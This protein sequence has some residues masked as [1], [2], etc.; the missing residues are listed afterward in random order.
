MQQNVLCTTSSTSYY[1]YYRAWVV[2]EELSSL[3]DPSL[4]GTKE[5]PYKLL[6]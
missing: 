5:Q 1:Y 4:T 6:L 3:R 2:A